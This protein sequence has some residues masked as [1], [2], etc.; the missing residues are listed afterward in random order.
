MKTRGQEDRKTQV[1]M[2]GRQQVRRSG[3]LEE[4]AKVP[5]RR[6]H[7]IINTIVYTVHC[8]LYTDN[9]RLNTWI[10]YTLH[11]TLYTFPCTLS[12]VN[13]TLNTIHYTPAIP[14]PH[15]SRRKTFCLQA[16]NQRGW[17][18]FR[19]EYLQRWQGRFVARL[20][21]KWRLWYTCDWHK[22][23]WKH[24]TW[25]WFL[26]VVHCAVFTLQW[27]VYSVQ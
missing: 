17:S 21:Q 3:V 6:R 9:D 13:Q 19:W 5:N 1:P 25:L 20:I 27:T 24:L 8:T 16:R 7:M 18:I 10:L 2:T 11:C 15:A 12:P 26:V 23:A 22:L 14:A 4:S